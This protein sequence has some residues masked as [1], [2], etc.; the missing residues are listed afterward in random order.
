MAVCIS[1]LCACQPRQE[2]LFTD[3][4]SSSGISFS[5]MLTESEALNVL[6][7][8][9]MYNGAG[10]AVGDLN[11][12]GL[13]DLYFTANQTENK[14]Y[15][16]KGNLHFED[17]TAASGAGGKDG[18]KTGVTMADVNGDG[19][20]DIYVCYSGKTDYAS[21]SNQLFI[22]QGLKNGIPVFTDQAAAYGLDAPGS[23]STQAVFFDYDRDG[24]LDMFLLNHA[25]TFYAPVSYT[26][27]TLPTILRV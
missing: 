18:W 23:N 12:D 7:F 10:V 25:T 13:P 16:N 22:N 20:L 2:K 27:L 17:I 21:R 14:L 26:H 8:E 5:N 9:Y 24:D 6:N 4:S 1:S 15:L 3:I 19:L 11:N